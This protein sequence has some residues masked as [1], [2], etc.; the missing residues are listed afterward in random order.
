MNGVIVPSPELKKSKKLKASLSSRM[1]ELVDSQKRR[2]LVFKNGEASD[3]VEIVANRFDEASLEFIFILSCYWSGFDLTF[4]K[5]F[6]SF[7][8]ENNRETYLK[9]C[10]LWLDDKENFSL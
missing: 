2:I 5:R 1:L 10:A 3:G 4:Q 6:V 8:K 9:C 7:P